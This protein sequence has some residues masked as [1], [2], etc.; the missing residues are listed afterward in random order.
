MTPSR[1]RTVP[2]QLIS[3]LKLTRVITATDG[4]AVGFEA[5]IVDIQLNAEDHVPALPV[6]AHLAT[7]RERSVVAGGAGIA[8]GRLPGVDAA[9]AGVDTNVRA[10]E[11]ATDAA[12]RLGRSALLHA[13]GLG[14]AYPRQQE[15]E[16][17]CSRC[18]IR[19]VISRFPLSG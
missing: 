2:N 8:G 13:I 9:E 6:V 16:R 15:Q 17:A 3:S 11:Q 1:P 5:D 14:I 10:S 12:V 18:K 7:T 4:S 19:M